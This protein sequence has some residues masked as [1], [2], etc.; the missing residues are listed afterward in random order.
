MNSTVPDVAEGHT[1]Y[2]G[3]YTTATEILGKIDNLMEDQ[4]FEDEKPSP[5]SGDIFRIDV[6]VTKL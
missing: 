1:F 5:Y 3:Y 4:G 2:V 6:K